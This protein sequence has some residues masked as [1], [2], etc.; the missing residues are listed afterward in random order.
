MADCCICKQKVGFGGKS[1][2]VKD[3]RDPKYLERVY[4]D[5]VRAGFPFEALVDGKND[6]EEICNNCS[7]IVSDKKKTVQE[8]M[9]ELLGKS[10][11]LE[12]MEAEK[13]EIEESKKQIQEKF[14]KKT[15]KYKQNWDKNGIVQFKNERI[16]I[17]QRMWGQQVQFIIAYDELTEEGYRLMAIDEGKTVGQGGATGGANAY[18]YFQNM[19]YVK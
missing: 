15:P 1:A 18:F 4:K 3:Y 12:D 10:E 16:A 5:A 9:D 11:M 14:K 13:E 17:L 19:K 8:R 7:Y 6:D 2:N